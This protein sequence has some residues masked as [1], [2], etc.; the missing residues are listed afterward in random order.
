MEVEEELTQISPWR[1]Y[2]ILKRRI[3]VAKL[4]EHLSCRCCI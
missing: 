1:A 2:D 3:T 4:F